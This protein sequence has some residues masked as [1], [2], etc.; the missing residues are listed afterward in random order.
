MAVIE[1]FCLEG[2]EKGVKAR[3][4]TTRYVT[5]LLLYELLKYLQLLHCKKVSWISWSY[6]AIGWDQICFICSVA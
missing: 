4:D 6:A 5:N 2:I 1:I 3:Y